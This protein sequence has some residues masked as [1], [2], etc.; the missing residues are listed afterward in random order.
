MEHVDVVN[1]ES[2]LKKKS[3]WQKTKTGAV[4]LFAS[5][6]IFTSY[7]AYEN[8]EYSAKEKAIQES[9]FSG[10]YDQARQ[11]CLEQSINYVPLDIWVTQKAPEELKSAAKSIGMLKDT[12]LQEYEKRKIKQNIES[13][14][15]DETEEETLR[16][17]RY[18]GSF[19][20]DIDSLAATPLAKDYLGRI[21]SAENNQ[22]PA[23]SMTDKAFLVKVLLEYEKNT[24]R[25]TSSS[26]YD[27]YYE[28]KAE[29]LL[30][31]SA[32]EPVSAFQIQNLYL[33]AINA[34]TD[35]MILDTSSDS[36]R[37]DVLRLRI[38]EMTSRFN[39]IDQYISA[40]KHVKNN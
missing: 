22:A 29:I 20:P 9:Y 23:L 11:G 35:R 13:R 28:K 25:K 27:E 18:V 2:P 30:H 37:N 26:N 24:V 10:N 19:S 17:V 3:F 7:V 4:I 12:T 5:A 8:A 39:R 6:A 34:L 36:A 32:K 14:L 1:C 33:Q 31:K 21:N 40:L 16:L 15:F 38:Q